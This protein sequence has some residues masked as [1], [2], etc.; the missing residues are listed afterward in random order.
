MGAEKWLVRKVLKKKVDVAENETLIWMCEVTKIDKV[1]NKLTGGTS[2][3]VDIWQK[4]Q[5]RRRQ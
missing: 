1:R 5:K 4:L 2:K 3:D